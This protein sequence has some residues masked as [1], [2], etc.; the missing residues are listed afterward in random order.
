MTINSILFFFFLENI[1]VITTII[2]LMRKYIIHLVNYFWKKKN[3]FQTKIC[4]R[5]TLYLNKFKNKRFYCDFTRTKKKINEMSIRYLK[6][7][8]FS[9]CRWVFKCRWKK[10][11]K[12][13]LSFLHSLTIVS[14]KNVHRMIDVTRRTDNEWNFVLM[15]IKFSLF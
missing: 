15:T 12:N 9:L 3:V 8:L 14:E 13:R 1:F 11:G 10:F 7:I 6:V 4:A 5:A 2:C